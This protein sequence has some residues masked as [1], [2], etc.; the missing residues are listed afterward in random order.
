[1]F[2]SFSIPSHYFLL[3]LAMIGLTAGA[4]YLVE[5]AAKIAKYFGMSELIIGLTDVAMGTSAPEFVVTFISALKGIGGVSLGNVVG[6]NVFNLGLILGLL[7]LFRPLVTSRELIFRD[8]LMHMAGASL[9]FFMAGFDFELGRVEGSFLLLLFVLYLL[10]LFRRGRSP[11]SEEIPDVPHDEVHL[12][13]SVFQTMVGLGLILICSHVLVSS[14]VIVAR[15]YGMSEWLIGVT[16]V[17]CGTSLPELA[18]SI[19]S[20]VKKRYDIGIGNLIGSDIFN[21][22]G[23][24]GLT[25]ILKPIQI[26]SVA[27]YSLLGLLGTTILLAIFMRTNWR[28]GRREGAVLIVIALLR[29]AFDGFYGG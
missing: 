2:D 29:W 8:C 3:V 27:Q 7:A 23:V 19:M 1:M 26:Q 24:L 17:A 5:G 21:L 6:S 9:L 28:L 4:H 15:Y 16:I 13:Q 11:L 22:L 14:S 20:I 10:A 25:S 12:V 18:T